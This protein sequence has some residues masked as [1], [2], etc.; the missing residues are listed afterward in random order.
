MPIRGMGNAIAIC[1]MSAIYWGLN[2]G[3]FQEKIRNSGLSPE[4]FLD[5]LVAAL[6]ETRLRR[7]RSG[8]NS[9]AF[10]GTRLRAALNS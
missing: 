10:K 5:F 6:V 2:G 7:A 4:L 8:E 1:R 3:S 9:S